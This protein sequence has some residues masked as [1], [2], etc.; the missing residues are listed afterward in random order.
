MRSSDFVTV[1][2]PLTDETRHIISHEELALLPPGAV[3]V[4]MARGGV[5]DEEAFA[6]A[7]SERRIVGAS[8]VFESEPTTLDEPIVSPLASLDG[9]QG[10]HHIGGLTKEAQDAVGQNLC[11]ILKAYI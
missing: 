6:R 9:F 2:L 1:H 5:I 7:I 10:T 4:N 3:L 11:E 8:D